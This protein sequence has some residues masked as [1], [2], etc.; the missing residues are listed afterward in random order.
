MDLGVVY[1]ARADFDQS[2]KCYTGS[3]E[4]W[5]VCAKPSLAGQCVK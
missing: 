3:L 2:E 1:S 4:Y 5:Q